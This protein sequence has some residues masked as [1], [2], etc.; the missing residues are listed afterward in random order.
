MVTS[1]VLGTGAFWN[2]DLQF[3]YSSSNALVAIAAVIFGILGVWITALDPLKVFRSDEAVIRSERK[4]LDDLKPYFHIA[5]YAFAAVVVLRLLVFVVP[6]TADSAAALYGA[7]TEL[8][9]VWVTDTSE[10]NRVFEVPLFL[11]VVARIVAGISIVALYLI[12]AILVLVNIKPL[13]DAETEQRSQN[14]RRS[15]ELNKRR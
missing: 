12:E 8:V 5:M 9:S 6:P 2:A 15:R 3:I 7:I 14:R 13:F 10:V 11:Q 4:L 1:T